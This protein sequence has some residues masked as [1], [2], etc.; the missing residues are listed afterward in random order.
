MPRKKTLFTY[1]SGL[2]F[3]ENHLL[4]LFKSAPRAKSSHYLLNNQQR[5]FIQ[6]LP[7]NQQKSRP[8]LNN[9]AKNCP[10][11]FGEFLNIIILL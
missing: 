1:F 2:D 6:F 5:E 8:A 10:F 3:G 11:I 7:K 4:T 9:G